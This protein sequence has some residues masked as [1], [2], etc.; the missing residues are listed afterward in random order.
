MN[1]RVDIYIWRRSYKSISHLIILLR[2]IRYMC[3]ERERACVLHHDHIKH[4]D[5]RGK[6]RYIDH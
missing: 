2:E 6:G 5:G 1:P 3:R 4:Q